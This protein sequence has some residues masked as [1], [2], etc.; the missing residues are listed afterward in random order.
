MVADTAGSD[1]LIAYWERSKR[2]KDPRQLLL[3]AELADYPLSFER[4]AAVYSLQRVRLH[5]EELGN[6][7]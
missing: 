3:A 6:R 4:R 7:A 2:G 5:Y 1:E